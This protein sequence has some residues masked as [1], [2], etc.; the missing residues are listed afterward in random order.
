VGIAGGEPTIMPRKD[1]LLDLI[2]DF[3]LN[4]AT[5]GIVFDDRFAMMTAR[6]GSMAVISVDAGTRETYRRIKGMDAFEIVC[7]NIKKYRERGANITMKY[8]FMPENSNET[9]M[10]GFISQALDA[11][12]DNIQCSVDFNR[13]ALLDE[14]TAGAIARMMDKAIS[15]GILPSLIGDILLNADEISMVNVNRE[16]H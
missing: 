16:R 10:D 13:K 12:V 6:P 3:R 9:D 2:N 1:E 11:G 8:I 4:L 14:Q 15:H 5:N 7:G